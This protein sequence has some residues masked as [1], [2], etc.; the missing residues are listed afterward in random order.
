ME[1]LNF[2]PVV[3][4]KARK[5]VNAEKT[6]NYNSKVIP[7]M[8]LLDIDNPIWSATTNYIEATTNAPTNRMYT[9]TLNVRNAMDSQYTA[10]QRL[11][12]LSGYTTWSLDLGDT[13]KMKDI[14]QKVK[15]KTKNQKKKK[16]K[17]LIYPT[18]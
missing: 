8:E 15:Q 9:K 16:N 11:M 10:F 14:K 5:I 6:L 7:E 17:S 18:L 12:F 13:E 2:S 4:I 1:A 3:G